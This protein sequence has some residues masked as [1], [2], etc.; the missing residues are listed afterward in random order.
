MFLQMSLN[1]RKYAEVIYSRNYLNMPRFDI[2]EKTKQLKLVRE[3]HNP[4]FFDGSD[5]GQSSE[6]LTTIYNDLMTTDTTHEI[7]QQDDL[8]IDIVEEVKAITKE[9]DVVAYYVISQKLLNKI[10]NES[11]YI[12][13]EDKLKG[14]FH[15]IIAI[16]EI[17]VYPLCNEDEK[18]LLRQIGRLAR[19]K[20]NLLST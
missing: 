8:L 14:K 9:K 2:D 3:S 5:E 6:M 11:W 19:E 10:R 4:L 13:M 7:P 18:V 16:S 20:L 1:G 17:P 15:F 12:K